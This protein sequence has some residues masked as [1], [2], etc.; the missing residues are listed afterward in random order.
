[1][2]LRYFNVFGERQDPSSGYAAVI[3]KFIRLM[4][5]GESPLINGDGSNSRDFTHIENVVQANLA[6][7]ESPTAPGLAIN[8][9]MGECHTLNELMDALNG[10]MGTDIEPR[11]GPPRPGDVPESLADV[12]LARDV[13]GYEP[14]VDW[15]TGLRRTIDWVASNPNILAADPA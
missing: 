7:A 10:L 14:T 2:A 5:A 1:V 9:A 15:L 12:S 3:P 11:Y 6:A 8:V 4:Q 13:L